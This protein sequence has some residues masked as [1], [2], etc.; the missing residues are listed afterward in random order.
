MRKILLLA[1]VLT[2]TNSNA[3]IAKDFMIGSSLDLIKSDYDGLFEKVQLGAEM[4]YFISRKFTVTGGVEFW[5]Q[6]EEISLVMGARWYPVAEAFLRMRGLVGANDITLGGGW[7]K[8]LNESWKFEAIADYYFNRDIAIRA[9][10]A[11]IIRRKS[12]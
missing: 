2:T 9:G 1:F 5:T 4:N 11:Y 12:D 10:F 7:A 6:G 8:P 3:Q